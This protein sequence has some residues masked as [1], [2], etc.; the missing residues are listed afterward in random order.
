MMYMYIHVC[1]HIYTHPI[2]QTPLSLP[3]GAA[4][5]SAKITPLLGLRDGHP[6]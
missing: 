6:F 3:P 1:M 5:N 2:N 4:Q